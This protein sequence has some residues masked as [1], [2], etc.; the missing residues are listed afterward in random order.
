MEERKCPACNQTVY[1]SEYLQRY[2]DGRE[3]TGEEKEDISGLGIPGLV[4][5]YHQCYASVQ[6]NPSNSWIYWAAKKKGER[7]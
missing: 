1:W 5:S 7:I 4:Y 3:M 2:M 6:H